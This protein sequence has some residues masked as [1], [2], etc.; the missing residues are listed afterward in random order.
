MS[1]VKRFETEAVKRFLH[2]L[3]K[4][5]DADYIIGRV[6]ENAGIKDS[7]HKGKAFEEFVEEYARSLGLP[8]ESA[9]GRG[10]LII[11]GWRVQCKHVDEQ[12]NGSVCISNMRPVK[13][14]GGIRG[15]KVASID[16]FAIKTLGRVFI[17]PVC[18]LS[19]DGL[20]VNQRV[21][22][23]ALENR[24]DDWNQLSERQGEYGV[25]YQDLF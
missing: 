24:E 16:Y 5:P 1:S 6:L 12:R 7:H 18:E 10:D 4:H 8:V 22:V 21:E 9:S 17:V 23:A 20:V 19:A 14:E 11:N 25:G 15:Y 13:G 3:Q 2:N